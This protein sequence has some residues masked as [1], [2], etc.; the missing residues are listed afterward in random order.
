M[1][2][3]SIITVVYNA[4]KTIEQTIQSVLN[5]TYPSI[6]YI[7]IDGGSTDGTVDII[8]KFRDKIDIFISEKDDGLY[9]AMNKGIKSASGEIIGILNSDDTYTENAISLVVDNFRN[10]PMDVLYG[11]AMLVDGISEIGLYDCS[12]IEQLW[13]RMAIPHPSTFVRK[14]IYDKYGVFDTQYLIAADY[15]LMLRLYCEGVRFG[16]ID[17]L[18]TYFRLGGMCMVRLNEVTEETH[19]ISLKYIGHCNEKEKYLPVIQESYM[20]MV[21]LQFSK[22]NDETMIAE[23]KQIIAQSMLDR[24]VIF[25][26]GMWAERYYEILL[27]SGALVEFFADNDTSKWGSTFH[28]IAIISPEQLRGYTGHILI[29]TLQYEQEIHSQLEEMNNNFKIVLL[30]D[31]ALSW[32]NRAIK[33]DSKVKKN[34]I[35]EGLE[36]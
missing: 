27:Q 12:D 5:Q 28:D 20:Q 16:H 21:L 6:E 7:I 13:Y 36:E 2:K 10:R 30:S 11:D 8:N 23:I 26:T 4:V 9:D 17:E 31:L 14:E 22:Q 3:V 24:F 33:S 19:T 32:F 1:E 35:L 25:G 15:D 18:L 29:G 34:R